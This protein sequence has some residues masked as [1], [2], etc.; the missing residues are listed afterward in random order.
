[1]S[2]PIINN[3]AELRTVLENS[4]KIQE[5]EIEDE[6]QTD[7]KPKSFI[8]ESN[9]QQEVMF[10]KETPVISFV[11]NTEDSTLKILKLSQENENAVYY[12][13]LSDRRFWILHTLDS[14][15]IAGKLISKLVT[16][17]PSF[18]DYPWFSSKSLEEIGKLG[19]ETGFSLKFDNKFL[20]PT[21]NSYEEKL[22]KISMRFWGGQSN[23]V[24]NNLRKDENITQG[25]SLSALGLKYNTDT[26]FIKS[27][28]SSTGKFVAMKGDS[29]DSYFNLIS[30]V[31]NNY[32]E[33]LTI[34]E[35]NYRMGYE[36]KENG[37]KLSGG[38][39]IIE[40]KKEIED[41]IY[42][43]EVLTSCSY[44]FR[45]WGVYDVIEKNYVKINGIDLHT[46]NKVN[47]ELTPNWMRI[48]LPKESCGNVISRLFSNLQNY[49]DSQIKL[50]GNDDEKII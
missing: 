11:S 22:Q 38:Y 25:V 28:I 42:F 24:I 13:D 31:K 46:N 4:L 47:I 27:N 12:L 49:F 3:R 35:D 17:N 45:L 39:T 33:F 1:M 18:L 44:P 10:N 37:F 19:K 41:I 5:E 50:R 7:K 32:K 48:F 21:D 26:G 6:F 40:F 8:I 23:K 9:I 36:K 29:V 20:K 34:L 16:F 15:N 14:S 30:K 2:T 43:S